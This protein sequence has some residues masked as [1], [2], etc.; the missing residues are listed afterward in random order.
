MFPRKLHV[1]P[2]SVLFCFKK[3][4]GYRYMIDIEALH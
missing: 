3:E 2:T 4:S 1:K